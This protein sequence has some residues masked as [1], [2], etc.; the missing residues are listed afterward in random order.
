MIGYDNKMPVK[1]IYWLK[2]SSEN[3]LSKLSSTM[4]QQKLLASFANLNWPTL[5]E[6]TSAQLIDFSFKVV[7]SVDFYEL[8]FI[9]DAAIWEILDP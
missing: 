9:K 8:E 1:A 2:Q 5:P 6:T 4:A 3:K 7:A